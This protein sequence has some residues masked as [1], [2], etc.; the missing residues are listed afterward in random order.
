MWKNMLFFTGGVPWGRAWRCWWD[1]PTLD[2]RG[3]RLEDQ[4]GMDCC[5]GFEEDEEVRKGV[6]FTNILCA[7]ICTIVLREALLCL[8][9]RFEVFWRMTICAN[10][11]IKCWWN[12]PQEKKMMM[13]YLPGTKL[14]GPA[15]EAIL[16]EWRTEFVKTLGK[17][18]LAN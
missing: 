8:H 1:V 6:N 17:K 11:L 9:F 16:M 14:V 4:I 5:R 10:L 15:K 7:D 2:R 3:R 18:K 13:K 12:W